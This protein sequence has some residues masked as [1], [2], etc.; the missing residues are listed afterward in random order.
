MENGRIVFHHQDTG[1]RVF[2]AGLLAPRICFQWPQGT[3][4]CPRRQSKSCVKNCV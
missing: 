3:P 2:Q 4:R 1:F